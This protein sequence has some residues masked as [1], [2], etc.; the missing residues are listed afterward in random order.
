VRGKFVRIQVEQGPW[1]VQLPF[2]WDGMVWF[3]VGSKE[4][5]EGFVAALR[6]RLESRLA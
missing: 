1:A 6:D 2:T 5:G 4:E 3:A